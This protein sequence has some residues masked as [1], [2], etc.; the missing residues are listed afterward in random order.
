MK[1]K[2]NA[3]ERRV[4]KT[5]TRRLLAKVENC[6]NSTQHHGVTKLRPEYFELSRRTRLGRFP[7]PEL[8][9]PE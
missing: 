5:S 8:Y 4:R 9:E 2:L 7:P 3:K 6:G 1:T